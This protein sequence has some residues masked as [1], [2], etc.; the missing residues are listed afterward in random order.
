MEFGPGAVATFLYYF[1]SAAVA[2]TFVMA[3]STGLGLGTGL[4]EQFGGLGGL[5]AGGLGVY[6]NRTAQFSLPLQGRKRFLNELDSTLAQYGYQPLEGEALEQF[7]LGSSGSA[8]DHAPDQSGS[9]RVYERSGASRWLSGRIFVQIEAERVT[10]AS[11]AG[12]VRALK[13]IL[14]G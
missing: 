14:G 9:L 6:F 7:T 8:P 3:R 1:A 10:F 13:K 4:P 5:I 11:R 12:T 2:I